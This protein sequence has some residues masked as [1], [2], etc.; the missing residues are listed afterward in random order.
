MKM[1]SMN[2]VKNAVAAAVLTAGVGYPALAP[3]KAPVALASADMPLALRQ[4]V[5]DQAWSAVNAKY[6]DP[7]F[8][9]VDWQ[10]VRLSFMKGLPA[11][12]DGAAFYRY[13]NRMLAS[14][15][16]AHTRAFS[17]QEVV[18][19]KAHQKTSIG[20]SP[21][22]DGLIS[23]V[24]K[25]SDAEKAGIRVGMTIAA[26]DGVRLEERLRSLRIEVIPDGLDF[27]TRA[28]T[29]LANRLV[30]A[31]LFS[32]DPGTT[33]RLDIMGEGAPPSPIT[34]TR[35]I[36]SN[37]IAVTSRVLPSGFGYI[38]FD[39]FRSKPLKQV[40]TALFGLAGTPGLIIDLRNNGG[41]DFDA[42]IKLSDWFFDKKVPF[43]TMVTRDGKPISFLGGLI[44]IPL[45]FDAGGPTTR[46]FAK[47]VVILIGARSASASEFFSAGMRE[48]GRAKLVGTLSCGCTNGVAGTTKLPDGGALNIGNF[49]SRTPL[50]KIIE[51]NGLEP[52]IVVE[53]TISD[54]KTGADPALIA[55]ETLL[56][57]GI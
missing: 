21:G 55:A 28:Q 1:V 12:Q 11:S 53:L 44:K 5:L 50:G 34:L 2:S 33:V 18:L 26:V 15:K 22:F 19:R 36:V 24:E 10:A 6:Y 47:P 45:K 30:T 51:G 43:G 48:N 38:A 52:D 39:G 9:G 56:K 4:Q 25:G 46:L 17:P 35:R 14:L 49:G 20:V 7:A 54:L 8:N 40:Q 37:E 23:A 13:L 3:A 31:K 41:G 32:G 29:A 42:M 27:T 57:S 16:D